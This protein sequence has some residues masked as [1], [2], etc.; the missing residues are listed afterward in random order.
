[1]LIDDQLA[2]INVQNTTKR[3]IHVHPRNPQNCASYFINVAKKE[4][5]AS[6]ETEFVF[7]VS[8]SP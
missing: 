7:Y 8:V 3:K 5:F 4:N 2:V 1:M 6:K